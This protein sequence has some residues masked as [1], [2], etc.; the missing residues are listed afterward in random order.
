MPNI[1]MLQRT[2]DEFHGCGPPRVHLHWVKAGIRGH[3]I[4]A[5]HANQRKRPGERLDECSSRCEQIFSNAENVSAIA[6][7]RNAKR[8]LADQLS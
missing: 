5:A 3:E 1:E 2:L 7:S 6:E 8:A 4:D